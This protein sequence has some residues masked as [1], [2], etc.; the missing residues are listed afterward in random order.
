MQVRPVD[1]GHGPDG[2]AQSHRERLHV[3]VGVGKRLSREVGVQGKEARLESQMLVIN[4][5]F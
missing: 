3:D 1:V 4:V 5:I 2:A